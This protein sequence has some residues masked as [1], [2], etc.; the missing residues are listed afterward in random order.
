MQKLEKRPS[1]EE[2][3]MTFAEQIARRST[4]KRLQVG[5]VI[6]ST[7][8]R[9]VLSI[10]YNGNATGLPNSCDREEPGNCG[11]L[12][13]EE[14]AVINCDAPRYVEKYVFVTH[15][16]CVQCAKRLINLGNVRRVVYKEDYRIRDSVQVFNQAGIE[17]RQFI[18]TEEQ[19]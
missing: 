9:K 19:T 10:G 5:T 18:S 14:N 3:Y 13:S 7:D 15:L 1:F 16:P 4:C 8:Y 12:H 2:I 6:T 11:C 17:I